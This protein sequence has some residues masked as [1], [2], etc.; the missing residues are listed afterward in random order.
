MAGDGLLVASGGGGSA[1]WPRPTM[2]PGPASAVSAG[3]R[4]NGAGYRGFV[5]HRPCDRLRDRRGV[6][7]MSTG[8]APR[9]DASTPRRADWPGG[10]R[11]PH[12]TPGWRVCKSRINCY[13]PAFGDSRVCARVVYPQTERGHASMPR[14]ISRPLTLRITSAEVL[15]SQLEP[16]DLSALARIADGDEEEPVK[17]G[18]TYCQTA[19][20]GAALAVGETD[21]RAG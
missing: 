13:A 9:G 17:C 6:I 21:P 3:N 11:Q 4:D 16:D 7:A 2:G 15:E 18:G 14:K 20:Q 5:A 1:A 10:Q 19:Y 8:T 12:P